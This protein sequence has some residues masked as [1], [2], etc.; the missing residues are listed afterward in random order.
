MKRLSAFSAATMVAGFLCLG[1]LICADASAAAKNVCSEDI[2]KFCNNVSPGWVNLMDCLEKHES[3]LSSACK[4]YEAKMGGARVERKER[5]KEK[6]M[7]RQA[8][9]ADVD[10]L[11]YDAVPRQGG[12][13]KCLNE[14]K[15][16]LSDPCGKWM[17]AATTGKSK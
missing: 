16:E 6:R 7:F 1:L 14:H 11:C 3:E 10:K 2:A 9:Q 15:S 8:C 17:T 5:V 4:E 12:I 13:V